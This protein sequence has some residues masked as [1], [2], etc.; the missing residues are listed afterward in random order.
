M[1][2]P[3]FRSWYA[4]VVN[5]LSTNITNIYLCTLLDEA[6]KALQNI[7]VTEN[8]CVSKTESHRLFFVMSRRVRTFSSASLSNPTCIAGQKVQIQAASQESMQSVQH[9]VKHIPEG[10]PELGLQ[11]GHFLFLPLKWPA[12]FSRILSHLVFNHSQFLLGLLTKPLSYLSMFDIKIKKGINLCSDLCALFLLEGDAASFVSNFKARY[13]AAFKHMAFI[14]LIIV[15]YLLS[16][17]FR[18][19]IPGLLIPPKTQIRKSEE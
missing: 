7:H 11:G 13:Y 5:A 17:M 6:R 2:T 12:D 14:Q 1:F 15:H 18:N 16:S 9:S 3:E 19:L 10:F 8:K 4:N